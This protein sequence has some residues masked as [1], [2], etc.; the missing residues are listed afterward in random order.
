MIDRQYLKGIIKMTKDD[1]ITAIRK[2]YKDVYLHSEIIPEA[3]CE[4]IEKV[5][6]IVLGCD[7][8]NPWR[9]TFRKAFGLDISDKYYNKIIK[10]NL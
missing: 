10:N 5:K 8:S 7:P 1:I 9:E 2:E 3:Y 6:A 4:N